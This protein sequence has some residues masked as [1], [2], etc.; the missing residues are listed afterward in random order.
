M[1][2]HG[3]RLLNSMKHV[4]ESVEVDG[5]GRRWGMVYLDNVRVTGIDRAQYGGY[6]AHLAQLNLYKPVGQEFGMVRL[7]T[8]DLTR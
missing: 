4:V 1:T 2:L 3:L 8:M 7:S 5:D 6:L